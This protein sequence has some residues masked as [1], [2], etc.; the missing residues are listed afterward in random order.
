MVLLPGSDEDGHDHD[1]EH[2]EEGHHHELDP[3][4]WVSPHRAIQEVTNIK[5]QLVKLYPK[6]AK[7]FETNAEKYLTKLTAL[8]KEFQTALKDAKQ[9][10]CYPTC[11]IWLSCLRLRLKTSTNSWFNT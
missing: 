1:H 10:F 8:D 11:C 2:G 6:K 5:E 3:H 9:K 7:T 4:T